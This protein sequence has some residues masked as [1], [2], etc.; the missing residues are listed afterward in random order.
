MNC[1]HCGKGLELVKAGSSGPEPGVPT[2][3][4]ALVML[5]QI[6]PLGLDDRERKFVDETLIRVEKYG[7]RIRLSD[8][9]LGWIA[10][11]ADK[12]RDG[13]TKPGL[14]PLPKPVKPR[15]TDDDIP[16]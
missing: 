9:Q 14:P 16:F 10:A 8:K 3:A 2:V 7:D 5:D 6:D 12:Q 11:I 4:E 1:P 15:I 13:G